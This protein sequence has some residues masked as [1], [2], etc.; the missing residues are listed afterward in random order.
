MSVWHYS[1]ISGTLAPGP[2]RSLSVCLSQSAAWNWMT[3]TSVDERSKGHK[4]SE[5]HNLVT[6]PLIRL[7]LLFLWCSFEPQTFQTCNQVGLTMF[8][9]ALTLKPILLRPGSAPPPPPTEGDWPRINGL[10]SWDAHI[11]R[12]LMHAHLC[13]HRA[14]AAGTQSQRSSPDVPAAASGPTC[15]LS[16]SLT[17]SAVATHRS[18][19]TGRARQGIRDSEW[20][21]K[22]AAEE[23]EY[24]LWGWWNDSWLEQKIA[25]ESW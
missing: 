11:Q 4:V 7:L 18:A 20:S 15:P 1:T 9:Y 6:S 24:L 5:R 23:G 14:D 3:I 25:S 13:Q 8:F 10:L 2:R 22:E 19:R 16:D 21:I 17:F 12:N